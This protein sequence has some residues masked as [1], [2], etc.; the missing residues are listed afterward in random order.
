VVVTKSGR[1]RPE[2]ST[3]S[4]EEALE[5]IACLDASWAALESVQSEPADEGSIQ[6]VMPAALEAAWR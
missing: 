1:E 6:V 4:I 5:A 3:A 2:K